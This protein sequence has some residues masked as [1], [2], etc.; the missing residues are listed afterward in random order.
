MPQR[1]E[2]KM[3]PFGTPTKKRCPPLRH[4]AGFKIFLGA[5]VI[6]LVVCTVQP[7]A[8]SAEQD[9]A[10][11]PSFTFNLGDAQP[12]GL[13]VGIQILLLLTVLSL[14]PALFIMVTS[15]TRIVVVFSFLRQAL[16]T[17][18]APPN[19]VLISLA[20]FLT[21]FVMSPVWQKIHVEA[22]QPY[23]SEEISQP[24]ALKRATEPIR[25]FMLK[26]VRE[27]DLSLFLEI[28]RTP[29][30][31]DAS[32]IPTYVMIPAFMVS[33]LR[34][35][36]QIGFLIYIPFLVIDIVVASILMSMGM[37]M[38]P[39]VMISLPFKLILFVLADGWYLIVGSLVRSFG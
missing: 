10:G 21:L 26:Q 18:Q 32:G 8:M 1:I 12:K 7:L 28:A 2:N 15:F 30:P 36:F 27:K 24:E 23:L 6:L 17:Q 25:E 33:E 19:Q 29:K 13:S 31:K 3:S 35:A 11:G 5:I 16:G 38:L 9:T 37:M 4:S 22:L 34:T 14:A 20:L 39:P